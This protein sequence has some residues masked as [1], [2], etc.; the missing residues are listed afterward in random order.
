MSCLQEA[1]RQ[2]WARI[3]E[4]HN[5][6]VLVTATSLLTGPRSS[7]VDTEVLWER[8]IGTIGSSLIPPLNGGGDGIEDDSEVENLGLFP[9]MDDVITKSLALGF[10]KLWHMFEV[11]WTLGHQ[12]ALLE[13]VDHVGQAALVGEELGV[14][15][16]VFSRD[17]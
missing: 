8:Q 16:E 7:E 4:A 6:G 1:N 3:D 5:P 10:L 2:V 12:S 17:S 11:V 13:E 14:G 9:A 15:H